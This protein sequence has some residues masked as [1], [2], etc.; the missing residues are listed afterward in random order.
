MNSTLV[1]APHQVARFFDTH[2]EI[3]VSGVTKVLSHV[4]FKEMYDRVMERDATVMSPLVLPSNTISFGK[5]V[6]AV[7]L[8]TYWPETI[9]NVKFKSSRD[10]LREENYEIPFPNIL[11]YFQLTLQGDKFKLVRSKYFCTP[12]RPGE[13]FKSA[14]FIRDV[15]QRSGIYPLALPNIFGDCRACFGR[16]V[17]PDGFVDDFRALDWYYLFLH[18]STFN[19]DLTIPGVASGFSSPLTWMDKLA[20]NQKFPYNLLK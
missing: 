16:N 3:E 7:E 17:M 10:S 18:Q 4:T 20:E 2:V 11:I 1:E 9:F 12:K 6:S 15:D 19:T 8:N 5:T 14:G 13:L